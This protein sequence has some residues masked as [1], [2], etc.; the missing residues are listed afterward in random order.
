MLNKHH[1]THRLGTIKHQKDIEVVKDLHCFWYCT[2]CKKCHSY[3][4]PNDG[5]DL[6]IY[7]D[8]SKWQDILFYAADLEREG[9][10]YNGITLQVSW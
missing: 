8:F 1:G 5:E 10:E 6:A 9:V 2:A 3:N 4:E 7:P